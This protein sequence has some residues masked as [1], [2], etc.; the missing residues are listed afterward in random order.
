MGNSHCCSSS[1][2][3]GSRYYMLLDN[4]RKTKSAF[5]HPEF[6]PTHYCLIQDWIEQHPDILAIAPLWN[7]YSWLR[8]QDIPFYIHDHS[9]GN[10]LF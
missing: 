6:P 10:E 2:A 7:Q 5:L 1:G 4:C 3:V 9:S 8:V